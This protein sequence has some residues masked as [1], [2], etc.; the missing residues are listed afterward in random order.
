MGGGSEEPA[1]QRNEPVLLRSMIVM[2]NYVDYGD[3][4]NHGIGNGRGHGAGNHNSM[5]SASVADAGS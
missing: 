2:L 5:D 1:A 3:D 4:A